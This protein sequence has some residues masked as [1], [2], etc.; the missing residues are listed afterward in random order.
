MRKISFA[1][2]AGIVLCSCG[3]KE[4]IDNEKPSFKSVKINTVEQINATTETEVV[5][6]EEFK[7]DI[8]VADNIDLSQLK[9]EIHENFDGHN[10]A[11]IAVLDTF[12]FNEI[13]TIT[14]KNATKSLNIWTN[15]T[16]IANGD[17]HLELQVLDKSGNSTEYVVPFEIT[18]P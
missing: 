1:L 18:T 2:L 10:H 11:K 7:I 4:T 13:H 17:Y 8:D 14:G 12:A 15:T 6:N 16:D 9:V 5:T 3:E